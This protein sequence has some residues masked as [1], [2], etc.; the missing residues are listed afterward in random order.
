DA[1]TGNYATQAIL[2]ALVGRKRTGKGQRIDISMLRATTHLQSARIGEYLARKTINPGLGSAAQVVAPDRAF[3]TGDTRQVAV[4]ATSEAEWAT[5][6]DVVGMPELK[7]DPRFATNADRVDHRAELH[8]I[9]EPRFKEFPLDYWVLQ[10]RRN[11]LPYGWPMRWDEL[12]YHEQV[13]ANGYIN[14][15]PS[16]ASWGEVWTGGAPY[17]FSKTPTTWFTTPE[18]GEH[19]EEIL[20]ELAAGRGAATPAPAKQEA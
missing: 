13:R 5:F 12:R 1:S 16:N 3:E 9:L 17:H 14:L 7:A 19:N 10:F 15:V 8:A 11:R 4:A 2:L 18:I 20:R 6:C